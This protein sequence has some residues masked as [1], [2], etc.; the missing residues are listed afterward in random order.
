MPDAIYLPYG[1]GGN[2][3]AYTYDDNGFG[4]A[5]GMLHPRRL[6]TDL[7]IEPDDVALGDLLD[8]MRR[9]AA[10]ELAGKVLVAPHRTES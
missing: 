7:L 9:L 4:V 1:G 2:T 10:G 6:P 5:M 8:A 3:T